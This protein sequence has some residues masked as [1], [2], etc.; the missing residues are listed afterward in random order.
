MSDTIN[1][2][3]PG[4]TPGKSI[5][6]VTNSNTHRNQTERKGRPTG[7]LNTSRNILKAIGI[8]Q[9]TSIGQV[10]DK[11]E[12][13]QMRTTGLMEL[14]DSE[15]AAELSGIDTRALPGT[16]RTKQPTRNG[17]YN[18]L[19]ILGPVPTVHDLIIVRL[20]IISDCVEHDEPATHSGLDGFYLNPSR[21]GATRCIAGHRCQ[22]IVEL[23]T[24]SWSHLEAVTMKQ[25][26]ESLDVVQGVLRCL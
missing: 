12:N 1:R 10:F 21:P 2:H 24:K 16:H 22:G 18:R 19:F 5:C 23:I 8:R 13:V 17:R 14:R 6:I 4:K 26:L 20:G 15:I 3:R 7:D 11:P 25:V 9:R